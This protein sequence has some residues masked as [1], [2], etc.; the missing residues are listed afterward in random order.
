MY[1]YDINIQVVEDH[2]D[3]IWSVIQDTSTGTVILGEGR[4][5][6]ADA[7]LDDALQVLLHFNDTDD[8]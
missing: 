6:D 1:E 8:N 3:F 4:S 7:A 2:G 5:D